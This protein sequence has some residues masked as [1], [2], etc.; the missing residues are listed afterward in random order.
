MRV[1]PGLKGGSSQH[2]YNLRSNRS[3][4]PA[5][6]LSTGRDQIKDDP[7]YQRPD[8]DSTSQSSSTSSYNATARIPSPTISPPSP[9][10]VPLTFG[11]RSLV[12]DSDTSTG[13]YSP[14]SSVI[15]QWFPTNPVKVALDMTPTLIKRLPTP[16]THYIP[17]LLLYNTNVHLIRVQID[18]P[19]ILTAKLRI[20]ALVG[21]PIHLFQILFN[22]EVLEEM[23]TINQYRLQK[24]S[25]MTIAV[26]PN[27]FPKG[28]PKTTNNNLLIVV[29]NKSSNYNM[30]MAINDVELEYFIR[31][32]TQIEITDFQFTVNGKR[33]LKGVLIDN[34]VMSSHIT[35]IV[36]SKLLGGSKKH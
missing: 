31:E 30:D 12:I 14:T 19:T 27:F 24:F 16:K 20:S 2:Q 6:H 33:C 5:T 21:L 10:H 26:K 36:T 11:S 17:L 28:H 22:N 23:Y 13:S 32:I 7:H 9:H 29:N 34:Y 15:S 18:Q 3:Y 1:N 8:M 4:T 35:V 25:T